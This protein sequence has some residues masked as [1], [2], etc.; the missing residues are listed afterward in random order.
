MAA[1]F[2]FAIRGRRD[3]GQDAL[4]TVRQELQG[5][6]NA[7]LSSMLRLGEALSNKIE[8]QSS[9]NDALAELDTAANIAARGR[10]GSIEL[11]LIY[12]EEDI[13]CATSGRRRAMRA[14]LGDDLMAELSNQFL[15]AICQ[16][17]PDMRSDATM[18]PPDVWTIAKTSQSLV[19]EHANLAHS[20]W[21]TLRVGWP[22]VADKI[23][24]L[25]FCLITA[26]CKGKNRAALLHELKQKS[27]YD[28]ISWF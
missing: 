17:L 7:V 10:S 27:D 13:R 22:C 26:S 25:A 20:D 21:D 1:D 2:Q 28:D 4:A 3:D 9:L 23:D 11:T 19:I 24:F 18:T 14:R 6:F 12:R 16:R 5:E 15:G 8:R